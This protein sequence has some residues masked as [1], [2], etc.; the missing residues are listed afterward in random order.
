MDRLW[1]ME[2]FVRVVE[3]GSFSRAAESLDLANATVTSSLRNL[4]KHLG[5]TLI[6]RNTRHLNLTDEGRAFPPKCRE[7]LAAVAQAE[8]D[9]KANAGDVSGSLRIEAPFAIG[10]SLLC[11]AVVQF[12]D[13]HPNI[14]ASVTLTN[15]PQKLIERGT[16]IAIRMDRIED[17]DL[18][19][20]PIY[21]AKYIV[22]AAPGVAATIRGAHPNELD[23]ARCLGLFEEG[24]HTANQW[25]FSKGHES[26]TLLPAGPL[27]FNIRKRCCRRRHS[28]QALSI[29]LTSSPPNSSSRKNWWPRASCRIFLRCMS[30][31]SRT[32]MSALGMACLRQPAC[33]TR[34]ST[35]WRRKPLRFCPRRR[36]VNSFC[37]KALKPWPIHPSNSTRCCVRKSRSG[38]K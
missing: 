37:S 10:H 23:P 22:C 13:R 12:A 14:R 9:V 38:R 36:Y 7:I 6:Q 8:S 2:V 4:E 15:K 20:R 5:V 18:V 3:C 17:A 24:S 1:G 25:Q 27:H 11:P 28:D 19:G 34:S 26:F 21:E 29:F 30:K 32:S 16:D 33:P 35:C 31:A